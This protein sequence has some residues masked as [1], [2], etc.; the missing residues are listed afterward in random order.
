MATALS[1]LALIVALLSVGYTRLQA[2][3]ARRSRELLEKERHDALTPKLA[4]SLKPLNRGPDEDEVMRLEIGLTRP[5]GLDQLDDLRIEV[6]D[7]RPRAALGVGG[8][9]AEEVRAQVW[10]PYR[11]SPGVDGASGDGRSVAPIAYQRPDN[12]L[13]RG[14]SLRLQMER[15][16]APHWFSEGQDGWRKEFGSS[17]PVRLVLHCRTGDAVWV[18]P[19]EVSGTGRSPNLAYR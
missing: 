3:E 19:V 11:F 2:V 8:P 5:E 7:D 6:R 14:E 10:G 9:S 17:S 1:V 16:R 15:T 13:P 12:K 18:A 4:F